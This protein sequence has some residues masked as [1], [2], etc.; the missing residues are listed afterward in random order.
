LSIYDASYLAV[1]YDIQAMLVTADERFVKKIG[2]ND[3]LCL[4]KGI[5]M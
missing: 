2:K 3:H 4:L 1:A 5:E